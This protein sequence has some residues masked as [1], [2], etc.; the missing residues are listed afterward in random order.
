MMHIIANHIA[1][2]HMY[3]GYIVYIYTCRVTMTT[4]KWSKIYRN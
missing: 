1:H 4:R 2:V 3:I